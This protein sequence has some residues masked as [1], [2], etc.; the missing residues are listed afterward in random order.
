MV[1]ITAF[2][3]KTVKTEEHTG[4]ELLNALVQ[5]VSSGLTSEELIS[6]SSVQANIVN[7]MKTTAALGNTVKTY[8]A[9][10][11]MSL[12]GTGDSTLPPPDNPQP[13][14]GGD[15]NGYQKVT[16]LNVIKEGGY[17]TVSNN[18]FIVGAGGS[19]EYS[20]PIAWVDVIANLKDT[21]VGFV[22]A[23]ETDSM[24]YFS[25]RPVGNKTKTANSQTNLAGGGFI[26]L[27]EGDKLSLWVACDTNCDLTITDMNIGLKMDVSNL[28]TGV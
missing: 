28:L 18:E 4:E 25:Q 10:T 19:G 15:Y 1:D 26:S 3:I 21:T 17:L 14:T 16:G 8:G 27:T 2:P 24:L 22:F 5:L 13:L 23:R 20:A 11:S 12:V 9:L 7:V 6:L